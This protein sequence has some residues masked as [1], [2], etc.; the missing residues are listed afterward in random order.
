M[1]RNSPLCLAGAA[2]FVVSGEAD[3]STPELMLQKD[4]AAYRGVG[5]SAVSMWK[6]RG[7]LV[8]R[9]GK[10]DV[11]ASD[12]KLGEMVDPHQGRPTASDSLPNVGSTAEND[13][14]V[15][16]AEK[17][18]LSSAPTSGVASERALHLREQRVNTALK[19]G[20]LAGELVP[21]EAM[22]AKMESFATR[23]RE[24]ISS[25]L[26]GSAERLAQED[27]QRS[28][29]AVLDKIVHDVSNDFADELER[30]AKQGQ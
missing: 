12:K 8:M 11:A 30:E 13:D 15:D 21:L 2:G 6:K 23:Y 5:K 7:Q 1:R 17:D 22:L 14:L 28:V 19:N 10:V 18:E 3:V 29:R 27:N 24:R 25:A 9:D 4:Y 16:R 20:Q 26:R